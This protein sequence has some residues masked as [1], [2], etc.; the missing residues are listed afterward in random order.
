MDGKS[1][2]TVIFAGLGIGSGL[3]MALAAYLLIAPQVGPPPVIP[4]QDKLFHA[5]VFAALTGPAV[6]VL[7]RK[8]L[9]FWVAHM[10][11]LG[12]GIEIVQ[13][14]AD[15]GRTGSLWDFL[16]DLAGIALA[17]GFCRAIRSRV[18]NPGA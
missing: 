1:R 3:A 14:M 9:W 17:L 7:P 6:L 16:A 4:F 8:Y 10:L 5:I 18:E 11:A 12:A 15:T 2:E 13:P